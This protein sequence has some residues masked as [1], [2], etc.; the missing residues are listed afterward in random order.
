MLHN[1]RVRARPFI[2]RL[3]VLAGVVVPAAG[4][5]E[6]AK[7][8]RG[9]QILNAAC[10]TCH[11]TRAVDTQALDEAAWP[12]QRKGEG[13]G[14]EAK[15]RAVLVGLLLYPLSPSPAPRAGRGGVGDVCTQCHSP[16]TRGA[17]GRRRGG[18]GGPGPAPGAEG[19][20]AAPRNGNRLRDPHAQTR[21]PDPRRPLKAVTEGKGE[22][23][24]HRATKKPTNTQKT[25]PPQPVPAPYSPGSAVRCGTLG[26]APA[27]ARADAWPYS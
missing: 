23:A 24:G 21:G 22:N 25:P 7:P 14:G 18:R 17:G 9:E 8:E 26:G 11:D 3:I 19:R 20:G 15:G 12:R 16:E 13:S 4:G 10:T 2:C 1:P 5:Q 6:A 27:A